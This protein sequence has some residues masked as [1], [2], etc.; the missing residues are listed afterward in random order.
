MRLFKRNKST[1]PAEPVAVPKLAI[2]G[3]CYLRSH[4]T[5]PDV[6]IA[7]AF[8]VKDPGISWVG[9]L[10]STN[11]NRRFS[12]RYYGNLM[13]GET[14]VAEEE[15]VQK[16]VA[17]DIETNEEILL[18]D[19]ALH[20]WDGFIAGT[21]GDHK[22]LERLTNKIYVS[23]KGTSAFQILLVAYYNAGTKEEL[24]E[25]ATVNGTIEVNGAML[26]LQ[27][28]FDD[29]FDALVIYVIDEIGN[30]FQLINEELA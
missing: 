10:I 27:D 24:L 9:Q 2:Q 29:A 21:Y 15:I 19:K 28:A 11:Q 13:A 17:V 23:K 4:L 14:I 30:K 26:P 16:V 1:K 3:P 25:E 22:S 5:V 18:F 12:I 7:D 6:E 20:G 8:K